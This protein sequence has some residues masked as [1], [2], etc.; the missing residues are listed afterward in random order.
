MPSSDTM[1]VQVRHGIVMSL[2]ADHRVASTYVAVEQGT[3]LEDEFAF[4]TEVVAQPGDVVVDIGASF[5][6]FTTG[7]SRTVGPTGRV[8]SY[9]PVPLSHKHLTKTLALNDMQNV[10]VKRAALSRASGETVM[11]TDCTAPELNRISGKDG[12]EAPRGE[13]AEEV[14][15]ECRCLDD[16]LA[17]LAGAKVVKMDCEGHELDVIAGGAKFFAANGPLVMWEANDVG[18]LRHKEL[19][20]AW[21]GIGFH[22][23]RY[24]PC[25]VL[26]PFAPDEEPP[27]YTLNLF[28][29]PLPVVNALRD[30]G[31]LTVASFARLRQPSAAP[32]ASTSASRVL[33]ALSRR[34]YAGDVL[35]LW[36][37]HS[38]E[39]AVLDG[40]GL[41]LAAGEER[42]V[43]PVMAPEELEYVLGQ[44]GQHADAEAEASLLKSLAK[45][46]VAASGGQRVA[47]LAAAQEAF[48]KAVVAKSSV[49]RIATYVRLTHEI[50]DRRCVVDSLKELIR[51]VQ[52]ELA[53]APAGK[54]GKPDVTASALLGAMA[55]EPFLPILPAMEGDAVRIDR[56]AAYFEHAARFAYVRRSSFSTCFLD[57]AALPEVY[58]HLHRVV[59][60]GYFVKPA[61]AVLAALASRMDHLSAL[62]KAGAAAPPPLPPSL[63][64]FAWR[65]KIPLKSRTAAGAEVT[66]PGYYPVA[67]TACY[68]VKDL[69]GKTVC[70]VGSYEG[71]WACEALRQGATAVTVVGLEGEVD[72]GAFKA[73]CAHLHASGAQLGTVTERTVASWAEVGT[74]LG[75]YDVVVCMEA[76]KTARH[77]QLLLDHLRDA[78]KERLHWSAVITDAEAP[79]IELLSTAALR[80]SAASVLRMAKAAGFTDTAAAPLTHTNTLVLRS[81]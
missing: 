28:S 3:W 48:L 65:D 1:L 58:D 37:E 50:G 76:F 17:E 79:T 27:Q 78:A 29:C 68:G 31:L 26:V 19:S 66:T 47:Q 32:R 39:S 43:P 11:L 13:N 25:G 33:A 12:A 42:V 7:F 22:T 18:T 53:D 9:E 16:D 20:A 77:P 51:R 10:T 46:T 30:R 55:H 75:T 80:P 5:G 36:A 14:V 81:T 72:W 63:A 2:P 35:K 24:L 8:V 64:A 73:V 52:A 57:A 23:F 69:C 45:E 54:D 34:K 49:G 44:I 60:S 40:W 62:P 21:R 38:M 15:V 61:A 56:A 67:D 74:G 4:L 71:F 59:A 41:Y 6:F 70:V